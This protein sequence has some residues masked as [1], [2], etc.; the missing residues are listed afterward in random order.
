MDVGPGE[1]AEVDR[2]RVAPTAAAQ[3]NQRRRL[4]ERRPRRE[5]AAADKVGDAVVALLRQHHVGAA[6]GEDHVVAAAGRDEV[7]ADAAEGDPRRDRVGA[8]RADQVQPLHLG[9]LHDVEDRQAVMGQSDEVARA[10]RVLA[11]GPAEAARHAPPEVAARIVQHQRVDPA[12]A[13]DNIGDP[14]AR[15]ARVQHIVGAVAEEG[16]G[17]VAAPQVLDAGQ[18]VARRRA[19]ESPPGRQQDDHPVAVGIVRPVDARAADQDVVAQPAVQPVGPVVADQHVVEAAALHVLDVDQPVALRVAAGEAPRGEVDLHLAIGCQIAGGVAAGAAVQNVRPAA[20]LQIVVAGP[21]AQDVVARAAEQHVVAVAAKQF[22][23]PAAAA[24]HVG[25]VAAV[26]EGADGHV[27]RDHHRIVAGAAERHDPVGAGQ[28]LHEGAEIHRQRVGGRH[29][30]IV[31]GQRD[32]VDL[33]AVARGIDRAVDDAQRRERPHV[34]Q[35]VQPARA[36]LQRGEPGLDVAAALDAAEGEIDQR[37]L[38]QRDA[39]AD[40]ERPETDLGADR[41]ARGDPAVDLQETPRQI[42]QPHPL[43]REGGRG[44]TG[45]AALNRQ[46]RNADAD[47]RAHLRAGVEEG[48]GHGLVDAVGVLPRQQ[49]PRRQRAGRQVDPVDETPVRHRQRGGVIAD[50]KP[51]LG[52]EIGGQR[53]PY[54]AEDRK[55]LVDAG[56]KGLCRQIIGDQRH[57]LRGAGQLREQ[58]VQHQRGVLDQRDRHAARRQQRRVAET[59]ASAGDEALRRLHRLGE[60]ARRGEQRLGEFDGQQTV[61]HRRLEGRQGAVGAEADAAQRDAPLAAG[62]VAKLAQHPQRLGEGRQRLQRAVG[63]VLVAQIEAHE[64]EDRHHPVAVRVGNGVDATQQEGHGPH[65]VIDDRQRV[66]QRVDD[67][68]DGAVVQ[69]QFGHRPQ[70]LRQRVE[71]RPQLDREG[72]IGRGR[73]GQIRRAPGHRD[74]DME[75]RQQVE[76]R[77]GLQPKL[78]RRRSRDT[79]GDAAGRQ[80]GEVDAENKAQLR[81]VAR[82]ADQHVQRAQPRRAAGVE[83]HVERQRHLVAVRGCE[84]QRVSRHRV[85]ELRIKRRG[86]GGRRAG[87]QVEAQR[88]AALIHGDRPERHRCAFRRHDAERDRAVFR[89]RADPLHGVQRRDQRA[90]VGPG[91]RKGRREP[92]DDVVESEGVEGAVQRP[93]D[94]G[95]VAVQRLPDGQRG[96]LIEGLRGA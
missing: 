67:V 66:G 73:G 42:G 35:Q 40:V 44:E 15:K 55:E 6:P 23:V 78:Q 59:G 3:M 34:Q 56:L 51:D 91:A 48:D 17:A 7:A 50:L 69:Q 12:A 75:G 19:A 5:A 92:R 85:D 81:P 43:L 84:A 94:Q 26:D 2:Q 21:A 31:D 79:D 65:A 33:A 36:R 46:F 53:D 18:D 22:V 38:D 37:R 14:A 13:N 96:H 30:L 25:A 58:D 60:G 49:E 83:R 63:G 32:A 9:E 45:R 80:A 89:G 74:I 1:R 88:A 20:A 82:I 77:G 90:R 86:E 57:G 11:A 27:A 71:Q 87:G 28:V 10:L 76:R 24:Q 93:S 29:A 41:Q 64:I 8:R 72:E 68:A 95:Q 16:V 61:R 47:P 70:H 52:I 54:R 4:V 62:R 39:L